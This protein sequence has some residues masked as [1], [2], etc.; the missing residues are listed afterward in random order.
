MA[1]MATR[2]DMA[3]HVQSG[4]PTAASGTAARP[5]A[6]A[7]AKYPY[8]Y[9]AMMTICS[10]LDETPDR[11]VYLEIARFLNTTD[12]TVMG[13]GVGLEIGNS[14]FFLMPGNQFSYF[15]T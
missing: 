15:G 5:V 4:A 14:I 7:L 3:A 13:P 1:P 10:D 2:S 11:R 8:P 6:V 12:T 9:R